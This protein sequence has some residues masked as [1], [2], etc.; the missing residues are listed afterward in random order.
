MEDG[1]KPL[2]A[3]PL[4]P[5]PPVS[6]GSCS[7]TRSLAA[8][9]LILALSSVGILP[10]WLPPLSLPL[11]ASSSAVHFPG[12]RVPQQGL[13]VRK[14]ALEPLASCALFPRPG[15]TCLPSRGPSP[16]PASWCSQVASAGTVCQG[17]TL[18]GHLG[19]RSEPIERET[20]SY[21][22]EGGPSRSEG[23]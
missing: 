16:G 10:V 17:P 6:F 5:A 12:P 14:E 7:R 22:P 8:E 9:A 11:G 21:H 2:F 18:H 13:E 20:S 3:F 15:Q 23:S 4:L 19:T 1:E